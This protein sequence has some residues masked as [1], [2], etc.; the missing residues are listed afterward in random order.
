VFCI[1]FRQDTVLNQLAKCELGQCKAGDSRG[2]D[3]RLFD[4]VGIEIGV[5][6]SHKRASTG[7]TYFC[8]NR[9]RAPGLLQRLHK[10]FMTCLTDR[11]QQQHWALHPKMAKELAC[12]TRRHLTTHIWE[13]WHDQARTRYE[14][15]VR[16]LRHKILR[17]PSISDHLPKMRDC[18][19]SRSP[20]IRPKMMRTV[21]R[22]G[23]GWSSY[24]SPP[25]SASRKASFQGRVGTPHREGLLAAR[26]EGS[27]GERPPASRSNSVACGL[28][29]HVGSDP[30]HQD[31]LRLKVRPSQ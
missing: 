26:S 24:R 15:L 1:S 10:Y 8:D 25:T 14:A 13:P 30:V 28:V 11:A 9:Q 2:G 21:S 3:V 20:C 22:Q 5:R 7:A 12:R 17:P 29:I 18:I 31:R 4:F 23:S 19:R 27:T 16:S 6:I